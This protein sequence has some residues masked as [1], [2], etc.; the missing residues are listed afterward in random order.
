MRITH[1]CATAAAAVALALTGTTAAFGAAGPAANPDAA[2]LQAVHQSNLTEIAAG[3]D[4]RAHAKSDCVKQVA[5]V[6]VR[7]HT[8]LDAKGAAL[9]K[10]KNISMP[11]EPSAAQQRQL[12]A[13]K[14][15]NGTAAYDSAWLKAM[16][17]GHREALTLIDKELNSGKDK[18]IQAAAKAARPIVAS[19]LDMVKDGVCHASPPSSSASPHS[20][21][22]P[23]PK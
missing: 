19:H 8:T 17:S 23:S 4:A 6:L 3:K 2:F 10:T 12:A 22:S 21:S 11:K 9:A 16:S 5:D 7:D 15:M 20:S 13:L 1:T 14:P 18:D